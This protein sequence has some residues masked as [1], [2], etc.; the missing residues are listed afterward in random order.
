MVLALV[1]DSTMTR[2][3]PSAP[4]AGAASSGSSGAAALRA[5]LVAG[6]GFAAFL[7]LVTGSF[8]FFLTGTAQPFFK[9][10]K[11]ASLPP[12]LLARKLHHVRGD[13][14]RGLAIGFN[15]RVRLEIERLALLQEIAHPR[16]G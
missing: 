16:L 5:R 3:L 9:M 11:D 7:R 13:L 10:R 2:A 8:V 4:P 6:F 14:L 1:G 12:G 15:L